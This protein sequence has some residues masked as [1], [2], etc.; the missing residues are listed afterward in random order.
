[1]SRRRDSRTNSVELL[2]VLHEIQQQLEPSL[3]R[4]GGAGSLQSV[5]DRVDV[6]PVQT[7]EESEGALVVPKGPQEILRYLDVG[8][9]VPPGFMRPSRSKRATCSRLRF[10][11]PLRGRRG[12]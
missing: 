9:R 8:R 1:M 10:D 12:V 11:Q 5:A 2:A 7:L 3:T 4:R 6:C